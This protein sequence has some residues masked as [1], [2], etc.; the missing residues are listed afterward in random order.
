MNNTKELKENLHTILEKNYA[1][2]KGYEVAANTISETELKKFFARQ[3]EQRQNFV[4]ALKEEIRK[5][6]ETPKETTDFT[7]DMHRTWIKVKDLF[8]SNDEAA[9]LKEVIR[10]EEN[11]IETYNSILGNKNLLIT[12]SEMMQKQRSYI[13]ESLEKL[14]SFELE[15]A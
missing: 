14:R 9:V 7:S 11:A 6:G 13:I 8:A 4:E 15:V 12:T 3:S 2:V 5:F 1:A 10:G